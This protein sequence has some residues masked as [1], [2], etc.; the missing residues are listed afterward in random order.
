MSVGTTAPRRK[1]ASKHA[2]EILQ[3]WLDKNES[4]PYPD[5][6]DLE[7][8]TNKTGLNE[9]QVRVWFTNYR[10]VSD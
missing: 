10:N 6:N 5:D 8:L 4:C 2:R 3:E 9:K 7:F 1:K